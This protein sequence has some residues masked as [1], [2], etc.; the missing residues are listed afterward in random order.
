MSLKRVSILLGKELLHGSRGYIFIFSIVAPIVISLVISL[1]FGTLFSEKAKLGIWDMGNSATT[2]IIQQNDSVVFKQYAD[3]VSLQKAVKSGTVDMGI[4]LPEGFD[5]DI[6]GGSQVKLTG[7]MWGE[8]LAKSRMTI[9]IAITD[10]IRKMAGQV[11]PVDIQTVDLGDGA[12][13]P[14]SDRLLP[15]IVL[16]AIFLGGLM[17]PATSIINEKTK[18]TLTALTVTPTSIGEVLAAKGIVG[19]ILSLFMGI[20][21]LV[22][23]RAFGNEPWLLTGV[24][25]LGGIMAVEIGLILG[26]LIKDFATLFTLWKSASIVLFAPVFIYLFPAIPSWI[27]KIFPT[28]YIIQPIVDISQRGG[29]WAEIAVNVFVLIGLNIILIG[30]VSLTLSKT[31][32]IAV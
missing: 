23:N 29:G 28:Y 9:G 24:L 31:R 4:V 7:Y 22:L 27:G 26:V 30:I 20:L 6:S 21:I 18:K 13:V 16:M 19:I 25:V 17:L 1:L 5:D 10:A 8:S 15:I 2:G 32:A 14:W 12:S 11:S 3:D